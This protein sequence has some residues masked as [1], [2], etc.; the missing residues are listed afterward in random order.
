MVAWS[1]G[2]AHLGGWAMR[3][4]GYRSPDARPAEPP[5]PAPKRVRTNRWTWVRG[6]ASVADAVVL[7]VP[8]A[9][10]AL[11]TWLMTMARP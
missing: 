3:I 9:L 2:G 11:I 7:A 5:D 4:P 10:L 8:L 6:D 1:F